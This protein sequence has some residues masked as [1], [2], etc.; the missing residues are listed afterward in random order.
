MRYSILTNRTVSPTVGVLNSL[1]TTLPLQDVELDD[2]HTCPS[3][4]GVNGMSWTRKVLTLRV[5]QL[6][7]GFLKLVSNTA[8]PPNTPLPTAQV[9]LE[10]G[11]KRFARS[12][13]KRSS[14]VS[15]TC[16]CS[17]GNK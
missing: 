15:R 4:V 8:M 11:Q 16:G 10:V 5:K 17:A 3:A 12:L 1:G 9:H 2:G 14:L 6:K 13:H 7:A